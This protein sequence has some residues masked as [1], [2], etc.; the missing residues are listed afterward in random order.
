MNRA[1]LICL[2]VLPS[3]VM[4]QIT[5]KDKVY[6]NLVLCKVRKEIQLDKTR[7]LSGDWTLG[8]CTPLGLHIGIM[9]ETPYS[10]R[11]K[12]TLRTGRDWLFRNS[13]H[14]TQKS[15]SLYTGALFYRQAGFHTGFLPY[16]RLDFGRIPGTKLLQNKDAHN[17][18]FTFASGPW[19]GALTTLIPGPVFEQQ[20]DGSFSTHSISMRSYACPGYHLRMNVRVSSPQQPLHMLQFRADAALPLNWGSGLGFMS[21][22]GLAYT[23]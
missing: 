12:S 23:L 2:A 16:A 19:I 9:A 14:H 10:L 13:V 22:F 20:A 21:Y 5:Q 7:Q 18:R 17:Y 11:Q 8:Y 3:S 1:L 4:A 6:R 15:I